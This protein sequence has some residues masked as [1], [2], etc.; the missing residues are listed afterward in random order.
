MRISPLHLVLG[1]GVLTAC[2]EDRSPTQPETQPDA[3]PS[4]AVTALASNTWTVK[5]NPGPDG[6]LN[7]ASAGVMPD[8]KGNP[9]VYLLGGRDNDGGCGAGV[10][11]YRIATDT[12]GSQGPGARV[13]VFNSNGVGRIGNLLYFSGGDSFCGGSRFIDGR[14]WAYNPAT[15]TLTQKPNPP[16]ITSEGVTG[17]IDG[18]LYVLPGLCSFDN[19]P[20]PGYC[21]NEPFRRLF[22]YNPATNN[23]A[24]KRSAPHFH[25]LGAGGVINGKFYV[26][27]GQGTNTLDRYDP[28][29]DS[30]T[31]LA[32][33]PV[34]G[35]F[36]ST[37]GVELARGTVLQGKLFVVV[38]NF[39]PVLAK[40]VVKAFSYNPATNAWTQKAKPKYTHSDIVAITWNGQAYLLAVGNVG[41]PV[42]LYTP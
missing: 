16:K 32:P 20:N 24:T 38:T 36:I 34:K 40:D 11:T 15:N 18:K 37:G 5:A 8:A 1:F 14:F 2:A 13:D 17:V 9:V 7:G 27:G 12:W 19:F 4:A 21:E 39:D 31:T 10:S 28:A 42:E 6:F 22:R 35:G 30:W 23:W 29:T 3:Q 33:L 25:T 26:A 41:V